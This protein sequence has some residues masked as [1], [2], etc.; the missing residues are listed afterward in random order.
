MQ[1]Q[2]KLDQFKRTF[3]SNPQV[4][5]E[6]IEIMDR[7]TNELR[8]SG[9]LNRVLQVGRKMPSFSLSNQE[10]QLV[11]SDSLLAKGPI[12]ATFFRGVW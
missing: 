3:Y 10:G 2:E 6:V 7:N 11:S 1:L 5:K 8:S 9:V 4:T 12:V